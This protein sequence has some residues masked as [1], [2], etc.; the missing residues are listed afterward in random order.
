MKLLR[1]AA[2]LLALLPAVAGAAT[3]NLIVNPGAETGDLSGWT[4]S[5][6]GYS[7][8]TTIPY[9]GAFAFQ[10]GSNGPQGPYTN[11]LYQDVD[12][13][14]FDAVI[15]GGGVG[16]SC[17]AWGRSNSAGGTTDWAS[18]TVSLLNGAGG[19]LDTWNSGSIAPVNTWV[20]VA[21][22]AVV[23]VGTRTIRV[24][25]RSTRSVGASSDGFHD[26]LSLTL[27]IST[28]TPESAQR[29]SWASVKG[30]YR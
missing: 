25:L 3:G 15:D 8:N 16:W 4:D 27:D 26:D 20:P 30:A 21:G 2:P 5:G 29:S 14:T 28:A 13:S 22:G 18:L 9:S 24:T 6:T 1:I 17:S 23:P 12:V 10:G 7:V 11:E 19:T